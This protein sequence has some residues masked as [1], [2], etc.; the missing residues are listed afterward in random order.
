MEHQQ[1]LRS[2]WEILQDVYNTGVT[3]GIFRT[4]FEFRRGM[5]LSEWEEIPCLTHL[6][7]LLSDTPYSGRELRYFNSAPWWYRN[8]F[9]VDAEAGASKYAT[10]RFEGVDYF[11]KVW[12]NGVYLGEHEGYSS[13]FSFEVGDI[14]N[15]GGENLL[16]CRVDAPW[17]YK[18]SP[19]MEADWNHFRVSEMFKGTY[20]HA[21]SF[22]Q[23]DVNPVGIWNDVSVIYH[24]AVYMIDHPKITAIP[25]GDFLTADM[26]FSYALHNASIESGARI[27]V[28]YELRESVTG[29]TILVW[30]SAHILSAGVNRIEQSIIIDKPVIWN[31][32]ERGDSFL[33]ELCLS[34]N[35]DEGVLEKKKTRFGVRAVTLERSDSK[36]VFSVNGKRLFL[37][38][39]SYFP[40]VYVSRLSRERYYRD[41]KAAKAAGVNAL[42]VHVHV[43]RSSFYEVCDELGMM[44]IQDSDYNWVHPV[45]DEFIARAVKIYKDMLRDLYN[46]PSIICWIVMNEPQRR[47]PYDFMNDRPGPQLMAAMKEIDS[48]RPYIKGSCRTEDPDSRDTHDYTGALGTEETHYT[49]YDVSAQLLNTEFG[50]D[51]LPVRESFRANPQLLKRMG[52]I[53]S[54]IT[55]IQYYG[56]RLLKHIMQEFRIHRYKPCS[57]YVQFLFTDI[58][59]FSWYG[60]YDWYGVPKLGLKAFEE[61]NMPIGL[62]FDYKEGKTAGLYI[63][64]DLLT[65]LAEHILH[66]DVKDS[67]GNTLDSGA[68]KVD[69][70]ADSIQRVRDVNVQWKKG[71]VYAINLTLTDRDGNIAAHNC[72]DDP[73]NHPEHPKGHS[74]RLS[75]ELGAR[76][77]HA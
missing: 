61:S 24:G 74:Y 19:G 11:C 27:T 75:H 73:L 36:V 33:Y 43:C 69:V 60:V 45:D 47:V 23:R 59:P 54:S 40:D 62:F 13:A 18:V 12:L 57:G 26:V 5:A 44:V 6:Q 46:H 67:A 32:W 63:V 4:D 68:M 14:L 25:A 30:E 28:S 53:E 38:A 3:L 1:F 58:S 77:F 35:G 52:H 22:I 71:E 41:V 51:P 16:M 49:H 31:P 2:G 55:D 76:L 42:R 8:S 34:V 9:H 10:L 48:Y 65:P 56:Y 50:F 17:C 72:Y 21:D 20:D 64:N 15:R 7:L 29:K 66:W 37:R 39:A 70:E